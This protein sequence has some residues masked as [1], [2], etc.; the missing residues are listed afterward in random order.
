M[1]SAVPSDSI[2]RTVLKSG[3]AF[4]DLSLQIHFGDGVGPEHLAWHTDAANSAV[5]MALSLRGSRNL[6]M[7]ISPSSQ[8]PAKERIEPQHPGDVYVGNP[9]SY[10]HGV[11]YPDA[12]WDGR[13]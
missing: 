4:A 12:E 13:V 2:L 9:V 1:A 3:R 8:S 11:E 7:K 6:W 5:H 10:V